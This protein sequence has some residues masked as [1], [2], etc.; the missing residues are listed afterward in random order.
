M[1]RGYR[2]LL[3][4]SIIMFV[5]LLLNSFSFNIL[6]RYKMIIFLLITM[7]IFKQIFGYEKD[8]H[9]YI[10][11]V[12]LDIAIFLFTFFIL[13]Y[14][15]G[16]IVGF[17][18]TNFLVPEGIIKFI[19]PAIF[20]IILREVFRYMMLC[21]AEGSKIAIII[22]VLLF[23]L[24]DITTQIHTIN[25]ASN[26]TIFKFIALTLLPAI[27]SN[28]ALS[29]VV[30][31]VGYKPAIFY[32]L[33]VELFRFVLPIVPAPGEYIISVIDFTLPAILAYRI[34]TFFKKDRDEDVEREYNKKHL[35]TLIGPT[36]ITV[37][38]VYFTSGY[39]HYHAVAIASGSMHPKIKKGDA[40]I[41]EKI[42]KQY[43]L[44]EVGQVI[45]YKHEGRIIVHRLVDIVKDK[46]EYYFYT[47][48]DANNEMDNF[49]IEA[50]DV[51]GVVNHKIPCIGWPTVLLNEL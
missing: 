31:K 6:S 37:V 29:Y 21:K 30:T 18:R 11:D 5:L 38:L 1:K 51:I 2:R 9:R 35:M 46:N 20:Y 15:L 32:S 27:S 43:E 36:I 47:K 28:V 7:F 22:V 45:A 41:I 44:L 49:M 50:K 26:I 16:I 17:T 8:K 33:I 14:L 23:I 3:I 19:I 39:F 12:I 4:F 10:K 48:G 42:D 24:L 34:Y 40:V 25:Y 13:Y